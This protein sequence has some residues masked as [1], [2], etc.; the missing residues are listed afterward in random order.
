MALHFQPPSMPAGASRLVRS[1]TRALPPPPRPPAGRRP[2]P[3]DPRRLPAPL[4]HHA[5]AR[6]RAHGAEYARSWHHPAPSA[7]TCSRIPPPCPPRPPADDPVRE[8]C[9]RKSHEGSLAAMVT[10]AHDHGPRWRWDEGRTDLW[11]GDGAR[12]ASAASGA[13][14]NQ[15]SHVRPTPSELA[16]EAPASAP[17]SHRP[18]SAAA[19]SGAV[20]SHHPR[21]DRAHPPLRGGGLREHRGARRRKPSTAVATASLPRLGPAAGG[22]GADHTAPTPHP[23]AALGAPPGACYDA[24]RGDRVDRPTASFARALR[25]QRLARGLTQAEL[26]APAGLSLRAVS[27]LERGV[28]RAPARPPCAGSPGPSGWPPRRGPPWPPPPAGPPPRGGGCVVA[29]RLAGAPH[30]LRR[31]GAGAR[32]RAGALARPGRAPADADRPRRGGQD[33]PG[34]RGGAG[35]RGRRLLRPAGPGGRAGAGAGGARPGAGP[36]GGP[37]PA[38]P[39]RG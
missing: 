35:A 24:D 15:G 25:Q 6:Q 16:P 10:R 21:P 13:P 23:H 19:P 36:P 20:G 7:A 31:P 11:S 1:R 3:A 38:A 22:Q 28:K 33:P 29:A 26:A 34:P 17:L 12:P 14:P 18:R 27:D 5:G 9:R 4:S 30:Q 39:R 8:I 2:V 32:R 37:G